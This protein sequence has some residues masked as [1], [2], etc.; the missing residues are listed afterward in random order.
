MVEAILSITS[1]IIFHITFVIIL[2]IMAD[3]SRI[4]GAALKKRSYFILIYIASGFIVAGQV[5]HL[6]DKKKLIFAY[7][8][9]AIG[10]LI[11]CGVIIYY[12][13]WLLKD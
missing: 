8:F 3:L 2:L 11:S 7:S 6:F 12:W 13:K 4:L 10:L 5:I 1:S 9:D